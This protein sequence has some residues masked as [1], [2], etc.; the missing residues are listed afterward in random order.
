M[1]SSQPNE[2]SYL[3]RWTFS[4]TS[5]PREGSF[6][7]AISQAL[8]H[9]PIWQRLTLFNRLFRM[10]PKF[11]YEHGNKY[12]KRRGTTGTKSHE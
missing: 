4:V 11:G 7:Y 12:L 8:A 9:H 6:D 5:S 3:C 1:I 10:L 2:T